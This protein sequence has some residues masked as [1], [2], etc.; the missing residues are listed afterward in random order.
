MAKK[1]GTQDKHPGLI[2]EVRGELESL[3]APYVIENVVGAPLNNPLM[4]CGTMFGLGAELYYK[5]P[6]GY[7]F[8]YDLGKYGCPNCLGENTGRLLYRYELRRH[9]LFESNVF[10]FPPASCK[11][12]GQALPVYGNPGGSS[13]RDGLKFPQFPAWKEGMDID[14]MTISELRE[15]IPPAYTEH[16]GKYLMEALK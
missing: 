16:I 1:W 6:C 3:E 4:L 7:E 9:R 2:P 13:K 11:H 5:C 10:I 14:W 15:S 12:T 8:E